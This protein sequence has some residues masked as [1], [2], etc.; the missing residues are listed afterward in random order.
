MF[1]IL[2]DRRDVNMK[3]FK[4]EIYDILDPMVLLDIKVGSVFRSEAEL[5]S[6]LKLPQCCGNQLKAQRE[7]IR[8]YF[9]YERIEGRRAI[10]VTEVYFNEET[11]V[12]MMIPMK[13]IHMIHDMLAINEK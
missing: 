5:F 1:T 2:Y 7:R 8:Q 12:G 11:E 10:R 13:Y 9:D 4:D 6:I 3:N